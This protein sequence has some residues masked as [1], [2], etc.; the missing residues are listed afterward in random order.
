MRSSRHP[1]HMPLALVGLLLAA[2]NAFGQ[3]ATPPP[4]TQPSGVL[5]GR[6]ERGLIGI[7][8]TPAQHDAIHDLL[9]RTRDEI[10][11]LVEQGRAANATDPAI[12]ERTRRSAEAAYQQVLPLLLDEQRARFEAQVRADRPLDR[13]PLPAP[14]PGTTRTGGGQTIIT[15]SA[16]APNVTDEEREQMMAARPRDL[17]RVATG[18]E[19]QA[20][21]PPTSQPTGRIRI[22]DAMPD[23]E[24]TRLNGATLTPRYF[25]GRPAVLVFGSLTS[26]TFR[27]RI[28]R[29]QALDKRLGSRANLVVIYTR[30]MHP[31]THDLP[32]R[33]RAAEIA[34]NAHRSAE[35]R[36]AAVRQAKRRLGI[37]LEIV[38][39]AMDDVLTDT[40]GTPNGAAI[41]DETGKLIAV[42][43]WAEPFAIERAVRSER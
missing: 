22:G 42:Q 14:P 17:P 30:E 2:G 9:D 18:G 25:A 16:N 21:D 38:P 13:P 36:I 35:D 31:G 39:D 3:A 27:D 15:G 20:A 29:I 19:R 24:L 4:A 32:E 5:V 34:V 26:P 33:N 41:F 23:F 28:G 1:L 11:V 6:L 43:T 7:G 10:D 8:L 37:T 12:G 40:F